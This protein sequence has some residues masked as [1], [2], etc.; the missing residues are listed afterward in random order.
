MIFVVVFLVF[1]E[2]FVIV[3]ILVL[4]FVVI[5]IGNDCYYVFKLWMENF[6]VLVKF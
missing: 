6:D 3:I 5:V 1:G 2:L 4:V